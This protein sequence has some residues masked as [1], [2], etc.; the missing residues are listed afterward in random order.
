MR[1]CQ[2]KEGLVIPVTLKVTASCISSPWRISHQR[3][4]VLRRRLDRG[5]G[6][7]AS[8]ARLQHPGSELF[9]STPRA[10]RPAGLHM[11][12]RCTIMLALKLLR[13]KF[14]TMLVAGLFHQGRTY[15]SFC[16]WYQRPPAYGPHGGCQSP[17]DDNRKGGDCEGR[18]GYWIAHQQR[19]SRNVSMPA[20]QASFLSSLRLSVEP[21]LLQIACVVMRCSSNCDVR[22]F[23]NAISI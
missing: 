7:A 17:P 22:Y 4:Y 10:T 18:L 19:S 3:Q 11:M 13:T 16:H 12:C 23:Q 15:G 5:H 1:N 9:V 14:L 20:L 8:A 21:S 6:T 2:R